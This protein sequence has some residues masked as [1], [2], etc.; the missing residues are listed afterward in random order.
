MR[1]ILA[2]TASEHLD[3]APETLSFKDGYIRQNGHKMPFEQVVQRA[4]EENR[5]TRYL[6]EYMAPA[7]KPLGT[8]GDM[9]FG[10]SYAAQAALIELDTDTGEVEVVKIVTA[11]DIGRALNPLAL[12]GQVEGGI[13]M[14]LGNALTEEY[15]VENGR[16]WT[17]LLAKYKMPS[18][19]HTP[20]IVSFLVEDEISSGPYGAKGVGE[21][22]SIPTTPAITNA[23]FNACGVRLRR[24]PVD[25]DALLL[26]IKS[27]KTTISN[28]DRI[29][30]N[31][32]A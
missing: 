5:P 2:Q 13:M 31:A 29:P 16:V 6:H 12:Q 9:H 19:K 14:C 15:I 20:E 26:A 32:G 23:I 10:F 24:L 21:I 17:D 8:E 27:G 22:S 18:I 3:S 1:E 4:R 11:T 28:P 25:Q 7:T 30:A